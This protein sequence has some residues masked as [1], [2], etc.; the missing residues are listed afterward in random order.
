LGRRGESKD[1]SNET[2]R[3]PVFKYTPKLR[4]SEF[5]ESVGPAT[6]QKKKGGIFSW[7]AGEEQPGSPK[8]GILENVRRTATRTPQAPTPPSPCPCAATR[9]TSKRLLSAR[10]QAIQD[11]EMA[12]LGLM[13]SH[14]PFPKEARLPSCSL[15]SIHTSNT[16]R[17]TPKNKRRSV[18]YPTTQESQSS[19]KTPPL[20]LNPEEGGFQGNPTDRNNK[21]TRLLTRPGCTAKSSAKESSQ[22]A[23]KLPSASWR[24][25]MWKSS[26]CDLRPLAADQLN[27]SKA[28]GACELCLSA[29][30]PW[31][32]R[33]CRC[34]W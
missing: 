10:E 21:A 29:S 6:P 23:V 13:S 20:K 28:P 32:R 9:S 5:S 25:Y 18:D 1:S 7:V 31:S 3:T 4:S 19:M 34:G 8:K 33:C 14:L 24:N 12:G 2:G 26:D 15:S 27:M 22:R 17:P 16:Q 11:E 30:R